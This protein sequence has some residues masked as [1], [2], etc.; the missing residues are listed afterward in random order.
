MVDNETAKG[1]LLKAQ[2]LGDTSLM[3]KLHMV[4]KLPQK[5]KTEVIYAGNGTLWTDLKNPAI[6]I[7]S[8]KENKK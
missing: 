6:S 5:V 7:P 8:T 3:A 4:E 1:E 2:A